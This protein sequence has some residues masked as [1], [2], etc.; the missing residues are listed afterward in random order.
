M[1]IISLNDLWT[2]FNAWIARRDNPHVV[3]AGQAD[4]YTKAEI[5]GKLGVLI[6]KGVIP[7]RT[8]GTLNATAVPATRN[9]TT[10]KI[11]SAQPGML[12]GRDFIIPA[13]DISFSGMANGPV[14][15][16]LTLVSGVATYTPSATTQPESTTAMLIGTGTMA[17]GALSAFTIEKPRCVD[18]YRI[19]ATKRG[20]AIPASTGLP[21]DSGTFNW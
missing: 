9:G 20:S 1:A 16:Y 14:Y 19:S 11:T 7:V 3:T 17:G 15:L 5:D 21:T 2:K 10:L 18:N 8:Y 12:A 4:A 13:Q 6:P